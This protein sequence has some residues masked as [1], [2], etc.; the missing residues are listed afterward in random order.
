M[1]ALLETP[2]RH[3][4]FTGWCTNRIADFPTYYIIRQY[5]HG[6]HSIVICCEKCGETVF[7]PSW[8]RVQLWVEN[9]RPV[10]EPR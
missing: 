1:D 5:D 9:G 4:D 8:N 6:E 10:K 2:D 7:I 3:C